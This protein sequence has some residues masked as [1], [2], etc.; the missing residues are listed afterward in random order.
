M[1]WIVGW[2][3]LL[4]GFWSSG[5]QAAEYKHVLLVSFDGLGANSFQNSP[6]FQELFEHSYYARGKTVTPPATLPAHASMV[7]GLPPRE[8]KIT[9]NYFYP[10]YGV[11]R[12][13]TIF[14][15]MSVRGWKS[16]AVI[17][18]NKLRH[19]LPEEC[20]S[21]IHLS[22]SL[23][24]SLELAA[25]AL[26]QDKSFVFLHLPQLD[27]TGHKYGW[28][29]PEYLRRVEQVA[30]AFSKIFKESLT[31]PETLIVLTADHGGEDK[32]HR[33]DCWSC[34]IVPI[35][36]HGNEP[37]LE[38]PYFSLARIYDVPATILY[39]LGLPKPLYWQGLPI[40][41]K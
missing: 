30:K 7:S 28:G 35:V 29:S 16:T 26:K 1:W 40:W 2:F 24:I 9:W 14:E 13:I 38:R 32:T 3:V 27:H 37:M 12:R 6:A 34:H 10:P 8:H 20:V 5:A 17:G 11:I 22:Y 18:K 4:L 15:A 41:L 19:I 23:K 36:V 21:D 25:E 31:D 33:R 39:L